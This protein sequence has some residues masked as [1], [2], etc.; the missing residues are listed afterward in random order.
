[1]GLTL[2][3]TW[4]VRTCHVNLKSD[5]TGNIN[6]AVLTLAVKFQPQYFHFNDSLFTNRHDSYEDTALREGE[7]NGRPEFRPKNFSSQTFVPVRNSGG[8]S[9]RDESLGRKILGTKFL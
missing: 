9:D 4:H 5:G 6:F 7:R 2:G 8:P 3:E 1:M